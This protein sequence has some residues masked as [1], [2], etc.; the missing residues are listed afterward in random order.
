MMNNCEHRSFII[1]FNLQLKLCSS[2]SQ[3]KRKCPS[4]MYYFELYMMKI[5]CIKKKSYPYGEPCK[6][7][8]YYYKAIK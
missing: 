7:N 1:F 8:L 3:R 2:N 5:C 4:I 6:M